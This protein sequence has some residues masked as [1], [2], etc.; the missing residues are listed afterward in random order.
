MK[1]ANSNA[2]YFQMKEEPINQ[3]PLPKFYNQK[4]GEGNTQHAAKSAYTNCTP[5]PFTSDSDNAI[6]YQYNSVP[7]LFFTDDQCK[8]E[9]INPLATPSDAVNGPFNVDNHSN[10]SQI[11][12]MPY[13][14]VTPYLNTASST[15]ATYYKLYSAYPA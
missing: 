8:N 6:S 3:P 12:N 7:M 15:N 13:T 10:D 9:Y 1:S 11:H 14:S 2:I 5:L 4:D